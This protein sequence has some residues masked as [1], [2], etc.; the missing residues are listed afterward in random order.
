MMSD[1]AR[2]PPRTLLSPEQRT[3]VFAI[4][5]ESVELVRYYVLGA[6][7]SDQRLRL[8]RG[9]PRRPPFRPLRELADLLRCPH[10][11]CF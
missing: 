6:Y 3:R 4:P 1:G 9:K 7:Q 10:E 8:E 11:S 5:S 2:L